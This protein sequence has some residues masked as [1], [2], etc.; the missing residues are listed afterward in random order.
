M[1]GCQAYLVELMDCVLSCRFGNFLCNRC[2][3]S[4]RGEMFMIYDAVD[5]CYRIANADIMI[6]L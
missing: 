3:S 2:Q 1:V 6:E 5:L 4:T